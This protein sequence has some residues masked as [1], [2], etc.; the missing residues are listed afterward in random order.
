MAARPD[1]PPSHIFQ[2][3]P[4]V[5]YSSD[6]TGWVPSRMAPDLALLVLVAIYLSI[7]FTDVYYSFAMGVSAEL[8]QTR[9][10]MHYMMLAEFMYTV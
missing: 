5:E 7:S 6:V 4:A 1:S 9:L 3:L 8:P 10:L 2:A